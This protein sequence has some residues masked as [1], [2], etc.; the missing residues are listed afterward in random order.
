LHENAPKIWRKGNVN[1]WHFK[2]LQAY[3]ET[4]IQFSYQIV[5]TAYNLKYRPV[6]NYKENQLN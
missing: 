1:I 5:L 4:F 6:E 3:G 2:A